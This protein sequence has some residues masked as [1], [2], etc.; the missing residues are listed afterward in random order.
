MGWP[1]SNELD[2]DALQWPSLSDSSHSP[3]NGDAYEL[4]L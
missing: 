2:D 1:F 4:S 3:M